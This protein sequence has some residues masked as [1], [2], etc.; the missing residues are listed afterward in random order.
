MQSAHAYHHYSS[1]CLLVVCV[2]V[3]LLVC[4]FV[5]SSVCMFLRSFVSFFVQ[6][7]VAVTKM[8]EAKWDQDRFETTVAEVQPL[9]LQCG[10]EQECLLACFGCLFVL[11]E[12]LLVLF[13]GAV[14]LRAGVLKTTPS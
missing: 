3:C 12:C 2:L 8:S 6:A 7:V 1:H 13:V 4:L 9:L 10:F 11:F 5:F 14:C